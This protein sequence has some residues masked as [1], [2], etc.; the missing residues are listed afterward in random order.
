MNSAGIGSDVF[1]FRVRT[2]GIA[3]LTMSSSPES[4][5]Y[6]P[7]TKGQWMYVPYPKD[8]SEGFGDMYY[9]SVTNIEGSYTDVDAIYT[10]PKASNLDAVTF[11]SGR[12]EYNLATYIGAPFAVTLGAV[13]VLENPVR[14]T[15]INLPEGVTVDENTG[16][17]TWSPDV[18]GE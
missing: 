14:Y 9:F 8:S 11:E 13:N 2:D 5:I 17:V 15:G 3:K 18:A 12:E 6:L 7:D 16:K 1:L 10:S 4:G